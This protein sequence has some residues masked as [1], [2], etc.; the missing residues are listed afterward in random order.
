[1]SKDDIKD[2]NSLGCCT[3][4]CSSE[5]KDGTLLILVEGD[6]TEF[7]VDVINAAN[8]NLHHMDGVALAIA[9]K[10]GPTI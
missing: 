5:T 9:E 2:G 7:P 10:G 1:M 4:L 8:C 3:K 6:I